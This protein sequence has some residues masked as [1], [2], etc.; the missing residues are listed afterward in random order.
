MNFITVDAGERE[1]WCAAARL[2]G[3]LCCQAMPGLARPTIGQWYTHH[4][5]SRLEV[6]L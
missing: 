5:W 3:L 6:A 2:T 1:F 4:L